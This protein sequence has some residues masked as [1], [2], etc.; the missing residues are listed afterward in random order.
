MVFTTVD[1]NPWSINDAGLAV[2]AQMPDVVDFPADFHNNGCGFAFADGHSEMHHWRST[3][4]HL[5]EDAA[6]RTASRHR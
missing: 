6:E 1:E 3:F 2:I 4:Y 5:N